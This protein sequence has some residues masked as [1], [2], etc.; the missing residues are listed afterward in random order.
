MSDNPFLIGAEELQRHIGREGLSVVD[1]SWYLPAQKRFARP[2]FEAGHLPGAVFF[3]QDAIADKTS[4]LPHTL[5]SEAFFSEAVGAL[6]IRETDTIVIYDGMGF[7]SAPR[8]WWMFRTFGAKDVRLLDGGLPAW[9]QAGFPLE[10]GTSD[11]TPAPFDGRLDPNSVVFL[12]EMKRIVAEGAHQIADARS[13]ERFRAEA[14]EPREGVRG[15]HMPGARSVPIGTLAENGR[16]KDEASLRAIFSEAGIDPARP[17]VTS[18]GSGVT[19]AAINFALASLPHTTVRLY[20][21][22]WTEWGS[23]DDTPVETGPAR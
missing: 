19:A 6:G 2:E 13:G 8:V 21:G 22:S 11:K 7:F 5:P 12:D 14:P 23:R 3:D 9:V 18:C 20:D 17:V 10:T 15:G 1:A 4:P 16:L